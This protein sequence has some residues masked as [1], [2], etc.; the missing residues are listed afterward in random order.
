MDDEAVEV[1]PAVDG[2]AHD[3]EADE[4][5]P[6]DRFVVQGAME[7][8]FGDAPVMLHSTIAQVEAFRLGPVPNPFVGETNDS[9]AYSMHM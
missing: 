9:A 4:E 8:P 1:P 7:G 3:E 6:D 5:G 2:A